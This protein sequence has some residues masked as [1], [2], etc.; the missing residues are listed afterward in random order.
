VLAGP[1]FVGGG[2]GLM[3]NVSDNFALNLGIATQLGFP[4]F[5]FNIDFNAGL[6]V[7]F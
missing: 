1:V 4:N 6:A 5:T 2:G 7:E 3:I